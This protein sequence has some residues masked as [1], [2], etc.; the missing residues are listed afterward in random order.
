MH[1]HTPTHN[2]E[3][4]H[5]F[6]CMSVTWVSQKPGWVAWYSHRIPGCPQAALGQEAHHHSSHS[7]VNGR[8]SHYD[9]GEGVEERQWT[10]GLVWRCP[11]LTSATVASQTGK[12]GRTQKCTQTHTH[13]GRESYWNGRFCHQW[14][15][16]CHSDMER[17][18]PYERF[19]SPKRCLGARVT[20]TCQSLLMRGHNQMWKLSCTLTGSIVAKSTARCNIDAVFQ[21]VALRGWRKIGNTLATPDSV[22]LIQRGSEC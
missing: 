5:C 2:K 17:L 22:E 6:V 11:I 16:S 3:C 10:W 15:P 18:G 7:Q 4:G 21:P 13:T 12:V 19:C 9:V 20:E 14:L 1:R 8:G